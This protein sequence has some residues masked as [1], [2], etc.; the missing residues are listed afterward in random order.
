M[1]PFI[2]NPGVGTRFRGE[3]DQSS[4]GH[5]ESE[6]PGDRQVEIL[7]SRGDKQIR[8]VLGRDLG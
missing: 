3:S 6:V 5:V 4:L 1:V 8:R 2:G 7:V